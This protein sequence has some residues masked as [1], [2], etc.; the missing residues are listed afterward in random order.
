MRFPDASVRRFAVRCLHGLADRE[1][2]EYLP[3]L[4]QV[5]KSEPYHYSALSEFLLLRAIHSVV[6]AHPLYWHLMVC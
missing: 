2:V 3:Q 5:I 6:V 1:L 4:V